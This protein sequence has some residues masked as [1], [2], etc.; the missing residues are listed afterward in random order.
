[1]LRRLLT[2]LALVTGLA[3]FGTP[4]HAAVY[5]AAEAEVE[6]ATKVESTCR[7]DEADYREK[8]RTTSGKVRQKA[9]CK[10]VQTITI[11]IPTV[12]FGADRA[13]E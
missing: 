1:M 13:Y 6:R 2:C 9:P 7:Q 4:V 3:A 11:V 5:Q 10:P 12:M 8:S